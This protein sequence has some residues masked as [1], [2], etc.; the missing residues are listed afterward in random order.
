MHSLNSDP[1]LV[2]EIVLALG[3]QGTNLRIPI[4]ADGSGSPVWRLVSS[5]FPFLW[6]GAYI[7]LKGGGRRRKRTG[8]QD[9]EEK[10]EEA[11][12]GTLQGAE[13]SLERE[14]SPCK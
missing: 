10:N 13:R 9:R 12:R 8:W 3:L 7:M 11:G 14:L 5:L 4:L 1:S 2:V 6:R